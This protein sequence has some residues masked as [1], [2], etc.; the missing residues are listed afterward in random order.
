MIFKLLNGKQTEM[1]QL[2]VTPDREVF[3]KK[4]HDLFRGLS[5]FYVAPWQTLK[6]KTS[7][8]LWWDVII[9]KGS[10]K[11]YV[12]FP[13]EWTKE[14]RTLIQNTWEG[15]SIETV[16]AP[17]LPTVI[18]LSSDVCE[19]KY[20]RSDLFA[21]KVD[22]RMEIEPLDS[23]LSIVADLEEGDLARYSICAEPTSR[24]DWQ[25]HA[26]RLYK[27]FKDGKTPKRK[28]ITKK[29]LFVSVGEGI[30]NL[31]QS[32][33]DGLYKI[34]G[35]EDNTRVKSDDYEKRLLMMDG[36]DKGTVNK[37]RA[38]V[39]NTHIRIASHSQDKTRQ[40]IIMRSVANSFNDLN[41]ENE[42]ER[43]DYHDKIKPIIINELNSFKISWPTRFDYDKNKMSNEE[44]G[45]LVELPT[46]ALQEKYQEI[47]CLDTRQI[48]VPA[49]LLKKG[50]PLGNVEYKRI[51]KEVFFPCD[52]KHW[53]ELSLPSVVIGGMGA[54]KTFFAAMRA[55]KF[56]EQEFSAIL[57]DPKKS[58]VWNDYIKN[59]I[60]EGKRRRFLIGEILLGL[61]FREV[62][63]SS[64][65]RNRLAQI[66]M[67][68]LA[69]NTDSAGAQTQRFLKA[70]VFGMRTGRIAEIMQIFQDKQYR[71]NILK[72]M[73]DGM[74]KT[75]LQQFDNEKEDRQRQILSPIYNRLDLILG[76]EYLERCMKTTEGIDMVKILSERGMCTVIDIPDRLN[77]REAK[78][79]MINLL[80]FKIDIAMS[81][82]SEKDI[83]PVAVF[84]DEPH[85]YLRSAD[86]W[87]KLAVESRAYRIAFYWL[88]HSFDQLNG[89]DNKLLQIIKDAGPH[90]YL[91]NSSESTYESLKKVIYPFTVEDGLR[92]KKRHAICALRVGDTRMNPLMINMKAPV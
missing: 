24:L 66:L 70:A 36:L 80:T 67:H 38:P 76:D 40:Q 88:F 26:E 44:L 69:D 54:G 29:E 49:L 60:P 46:A 47:D 58:E 42:L 43:H 13:Y 7:G 25:D 45:R 8:A 74:H 90:Y 50:I 65:A 86:L 9:Q 19:L 5:T 57:F 23:I 78:D 18:P 10:I 82:R 68:F 79:I 51:M 84:Y 3:N 2:Q 20:R 73:P 39:F 52:K 56:V 34:M 48:D 12:T 59:M 1:I 27:Q 37:M 87:K 72:E 17:C 15:C 64:G 4:V 14:I 28:R 83:Y 16:Y 91:F 6:G 55:A 77:S 92:I 53:D 35:E 85:R 89:A 32:L 62:L 11:F 71:A 21:I 61:D 22:N 81:L 30:T 33:F 75:T 41:A 63:H 31:L